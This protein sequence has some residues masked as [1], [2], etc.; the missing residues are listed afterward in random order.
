[1][2]QLTKLETHNDIIENMVTNTPI[3]LIACSANSDILIYSIKLNGSLELQWRFRSDYL[4]KN[5]TLNSVQW[6]RGTPVVACGG[7]DS[8]VR[9]YKLNP[10]EKKEERVF[11]LLEHNECIKHIDMHQDSPIMV[12]SDNFVICISNYATKNL[13]GVLDSSR[14]R[15]YNTEF[16]AG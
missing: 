3:S 11:E 7:D 14:L 13:L 16:Q 10:K 1:M 12:S 8:I 5:S 15:P 4:L 2:K 6:R 9:V